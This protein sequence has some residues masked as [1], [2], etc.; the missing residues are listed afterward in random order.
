M[1][2][3][4]VHSVYLSSILCAIFIV[5]AI[6]STAI[7]ENCPVKIENACKHCARFSFYGQGEWNEQMFWVIRF[8]RWVKSQFGTH[9]TIDRTNS[10]HHYTKCSKVPI[11]CV[12]FD[13]NTSE[14]ELHVHR[15]QAKRNVI[16]EIVVQQHFA[17]FFQTILCVKWWFVSEAEPA[18]AFFEEEWMHSR[19]ESRADLFVRAPATMPKTICVATYVLE[20]DEIM[21]CSEHFCSLSLFVASSLS[22]V[23]DTKAELFSGIVRMWVCDVWPSSSEIM[24]F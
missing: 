1:I 3:E 11:V 5:V 14:T 12:E 21:I 6:D 15:R 8:V 19:E 9:T 24:R 23:A 10:M 17:V 13:T 16:R 4:S 18:R 2:V 20:K 22:R 7:E